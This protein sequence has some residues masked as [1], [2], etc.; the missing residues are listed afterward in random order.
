MFS[1]FLLVWMK[2]IPYDVI[3]T[4]LWPTLHTISNFST[5][6]LSVDI[7]HLIQNFDLDLLYLGNEVVGQG[8]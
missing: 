2:G 4:H 8:Y 5:L 3:T 6:P 7:S 1:R